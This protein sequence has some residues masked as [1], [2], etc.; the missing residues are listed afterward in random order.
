MR[1]IVR[2]VSAS[3]LPIKGTGV[4]IG[5]GV[6]C[7]L[8]DTLADTPDNIRK[9]PDVRQWIE[10]GKLK[11]MADDGL[12]TPEV[13]PV[14]PDTQLVAGETVV[15]PEM[16]AGEAVAPTVAKDEPAEVSAPVVVSDADALA[17]PAG[18]DDDFADLSNKRLRAMCVESGIADPPKSKAKMIELLRAKKGD[19]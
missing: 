12:D 13:A 18:N 7:N 2:N 5:P 15:T 19:S 14:A 3:L 16:A 6:T 10:K 8:C 4:V 1:F 11:V 17:Q 9:R